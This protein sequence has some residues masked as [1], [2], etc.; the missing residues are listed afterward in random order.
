MAR[1]NPH[2]KRRCVRGVRLGCKDGGQMCTCKRIRLWLFLEHTVSPMSHLELGD[3]TRLNCL[4]RWALLDNLSVA[5]SVTHSCLSRCALASALSP[6]T[7]KRFLADTADV[8]QE[9]DMDISREESASPPSDPS[10]K[11]KRVCREVA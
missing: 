9:S 3:E 10:G 2:R 5:L 6:L 4:W 1:K 11:E 7:T 8:L